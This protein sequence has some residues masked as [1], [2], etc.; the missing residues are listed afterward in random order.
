[1]QGWKP[2]RKLITADTK[3]VA[4][5]SCF[6]E[7]FVKFLTQHGY[8]RWQLPSE[9]HSHSDE[10]LLVA[11]PSIFENV[12]VLLQ[13]FRWAFKEFTPGAKLWFGKDRRHFD[14]TEERR[15]KVQRSLEG[16]EIFVITLGLSEIWFDQIENEPMWRTIPLKFYEPERHLCRP[17]SVSETVAAFRELDALIDRY[18]PGKQFIITLSPI[19]LVATFRNQSAITANQVSKATLRAALDEFLRDDVVANKSRYHYFPSYEI[20]LNLFDSPFLPDN[21][22]IHPKVAS[23]V[24]SIFSNL[25]TDL[26]ADGSSA[27]ERESQIAMAQDRIRSLEAELVAKEQVIRGLDQA[28]RER[29]LVI[30]RLTGR[31]DGASLNVVAEVATAN[32]NPSPHI[33]SVAST[34]DRQNNGAGNCRNGESSKTGGTLVATLGDRAPGVRVVD[35][36]ALFV[37]EAPLVYAPLLE[38]KGATVIGFE[39]VQ[40][41]CDRLNRMFGPVHKFLPY[42]IGDG[43]KALFYHSKYVNCS[44]LLKPNLDLMGNFQN[45]AEFCEPVE[46]SEVSTI[47]LDDIAEARGADY[48]KLDVQGAEGQVLAGAH[49]CLDSALVIQL[50]VE[51][52]AIYEDQPVFGDLDATLRSLGFVFHRFTN[53]EGRTLRNSGFIDSQTSRSQLLWADAIYLRPIDSW[54][55]LSSDRVLKLALILDSLYSSRDFCAYLLQMYDR[56]EGTDLFRQY[57]DR[58]GSA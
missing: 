47:R 35:V 49:K 27:P 31:G 6:A 25:Y 26:P 54:S 41:E 28:A 48:I 57:I 4:L 42:A 36:G 55:G 46:I 52:L 56:R 50:E 2:S 34:S 33:D 19:P 38:T 23:T 32:E 53:F 58:A 17:A 10:N 40:V 21:R 24:L 51:F 14:A 20:V 15:E 8:N 44:S 12:F 45:L 22:H 37:P 16:G 1:M 43:S 29:L 9:P 39:P 3:V 13:Q 18:I 30:N 11:M 7:F 5:G